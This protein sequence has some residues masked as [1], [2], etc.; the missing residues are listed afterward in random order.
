MKQ[1]S[2]VDTVLQKQRE[3]PI[4][5]S[6]RKVEVAVINRKAKWIAFYKI[7]SEFKRQQIRYNKAKAELDE[8]QADEKSA[9]S[10][11]VD[12]IAVQN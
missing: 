12:S 4:E 3:T 6:Q 11:L 9:I 5:E 1:Q 2:V 8:A 10:F 7:E